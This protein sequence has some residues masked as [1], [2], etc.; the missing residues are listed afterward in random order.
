MSFSELQIGMSMPAE[1]AAEAPIVGEVK[2]GEAAKVRKQLKALIESLNTSTFDIMDLIYRVKNEKLYTPQFDT[3]RDFAATLDMKMS[4]VYYLL[5]IKDRMTLAAIPRETYE[6]IDIS[7]L[8]MIALLDPTDEEGKV[9]ETV[10][11][12]IRN[13]VQLAP[14][15]SV[16]DLKTA[17]DELQGNVG[18]EAW[19]WLNIKIKKS[20]K[21]VIVQAL[22]LVKFQIGSVGQDKETGNAVDASDG[23]ALERLAM[24][25]LSDPNNVPDVE[26]IGGDGEPVDQTAV[27]DGPA[28]LD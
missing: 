1:F 24:D 22:E 9:S 6:K 10:L 12:Q 14:T 2:S 13:L 28:Q 21:A 5:R 7:K 25:F 15:K 27:S 18:D 19:D 23:A 17:V 16:D 26:E 20:A 11:D 3:F 4:K 8:K